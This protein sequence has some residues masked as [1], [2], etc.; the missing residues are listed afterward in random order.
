MKQYKFTILLITLLLLMFLAPF[1]QYLRVGDSRLFSTLVSSILFSMLWLSAANAASDNIHLIR[2]VWLWTVLIVIMQISH[3]VTN[4]QSLVISLNMM[5]AGLISV[6]L[7]LL[8]GH[9]FQ[10]DKVRLETISVSLCGYLLLGI[11]W[12]DIYSIVAYLD[13]GAFRGAGVDMEFGGDSSGVA[14]Y[15]SYVTLTTLGYGDIV[16]ANAS[17]GMLCSAEAITGQIYLTVLVARLVGLHI[18]AHRNF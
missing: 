16:P 15:F 12:A 6:L 1:V 11:F 13:P 7:S 9:I 10:A 5:T 3:A 18:S 17:V 8:I 2:I 14:L 4:V